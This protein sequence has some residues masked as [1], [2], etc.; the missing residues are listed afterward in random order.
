MVHGYVHRFKINTPNDIIEII[1]VYSWNISSRSMSCIAATH[2]IAS[3]INE[4]FND[5]NNKCEFSTDNDLNILKYIYIRGGALRDSYLL[6]EIKDIDLVINIQQLSKK[7]LFHLKT[8]HSKIEQQN[9]NCKCIFWRHY[10]NKFETDLNEKNNDIFTRNNEEKK[11]DID[12][13]DIDEDDVDKILKYEKYIVN[14]TYLLNSKF[15]TNEILSKSPKINKN[16]IVESR[17]FG[18]H[19]FIRIN[20]YNYNGL[21]LDNIEF[22]IVDQTVQYGKFQ[23]LKECRY[24]NLN[25]KEI[26]ILLSDFNKYKIN[27]LNKSIISIPIYPFSFNVIYYDFTINSMHIDLYNVLNNDKFNYNDKKIIDF[28]WEIKIIKKKYNNNIINKYNLIGINDINNKILKCPSINIINEKTANF[29]FWRLVKTAQ[30]FIH[31]IKSNKKNT[32]KIDKKYLLHTYKF[33]NKWFNDDFIT[34][35]STK[36]ITKFITKLLSWNIEKKNDLIDRFHVFNYIKF[37]KIFKQ[38]LIK[39]QFELNREIFQQT[40]YNLHDT[41]IKCYKLFSYPIY[42]PPKKRYVRKWIIVNYWDQQN[43]HLIELAINYTDIIQQKKF[44]QKTLKKFKNNPNICR[45]KTNKIKKKKK[46]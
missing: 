31:S 28:N 45:W 16:I 21:L 42:V 44:K 8:Y 2:L 19:W 30:K 7:Y 29:Y 14:C 34:K 20:N 37:G 9:E 40:P 33:Y 26:E 32:W 25:K 17:Y 10:L 46:L 18:Y 36:L 4:Y 1:R 15:I 3:V 11:S 43:Y 5:T 23:T 6:R 39:Y 27:H 22:D 35:N 12:E 24:I 38:K 41:L 13:D